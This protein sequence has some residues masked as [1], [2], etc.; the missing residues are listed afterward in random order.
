MPPCPSTPPPV[1]DA[2]YDTGSIVGE[3]SAPHSS[4]LSPR[5]SSPDALPS[6]ALPYAAA[7]MGL[8]TSSTSFSLSLYSSGS[9]SGFSSS[10]SCASLTTSSALSL[11]SS[12]TLSDSLSS[13]LLLMLYR[14]CAGEA[15]KGPSVGL[16]GQVTLCSLAP[17][18]RTGKYCQSEHSC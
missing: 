5:S 12:L 10:H 14:Y 15:G 11:S 7:T 2:W 3:P 1:L 6:P 8:H 18:D 17:A 16:T 13:M 4:S 9:D